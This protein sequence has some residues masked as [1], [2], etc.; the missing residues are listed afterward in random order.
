MCPR[1][2]THEVRNEMTMGRSKQRRE[3]PDIWREARHQVRQARESLLKIDPEPVACDIRLLFGL[4]SALSDSSLQI[5]G[6]KQDFKPDRATA[7]QEE[8][9]PEVL[10][11]PV[12]SGDERGE[13]R[14]IGLSQ[15]TKSTTRRL[16]HQSAELPAVNL[17]RLARP[18]EAAK[19]VGIPKR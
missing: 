9:K 14:K 11:E 3:K 4:T 1:Y 10:T 16:G 12:K 18:R 17:Y 2:P 13:S 15:S 5:S 19:A 8:Q 6:A 7:P